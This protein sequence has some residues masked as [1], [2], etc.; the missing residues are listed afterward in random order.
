MPQ[1]DQLRQHNAD[2]LERIGE[3]QEDRRRILHEAELDFAQA[4]SEIQVSRVRIL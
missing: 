2:L 4:Q 3:V 1:V